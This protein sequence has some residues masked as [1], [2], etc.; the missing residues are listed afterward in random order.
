MA[1]H[2]THGL[3]RHHGLDMPITAAI[4]AVL[5]GEVGVRA[6]VDGLLR[7]EPRREDAP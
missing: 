7:R 5:A 6:A 1:A 2:A 4:H 3:A